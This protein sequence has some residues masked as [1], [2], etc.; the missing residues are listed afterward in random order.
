[1]LARLH[2]R[3]AVALAA[4]AVAI[5]ALA[6]GALH[7]RA[8]RAQEP[9]ALAEGCTNV[10][11]AY[12]TGTPLRV[13]AAGVRPSA[14]LTGIFRFDAA[15]GRFLGFS[16]AAPD[17][18]NDYPSITAPLEAVFVCMESPGTIVRAG[19]GLVAQ[20][21][22]APVRAPYGVVSAPREVRRGDTATVILGTLPG[23]VCTGG[24]NIPTTD[25]TFRFVL[26]DAVASASG[27]VIIR[28]DVVESDARG[29]GYLAVRCADGLVVRVDFR[30]V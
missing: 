30:V 13:V 19:G 6:L 4:P 20:P 16:P 14:S 5:A 1:M 23:Y 25:S 27:S 7:V 11:L 18:A 17:A 3:R 8:A 2:A 26:V 12:P 15:L 22:P 9:A 24:V 21:T 29:F 10:T 28:F